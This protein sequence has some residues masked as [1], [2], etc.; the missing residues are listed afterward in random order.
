MQISSGQFRSPQTPQYLC[1]YPSHKH[2]LPTTCKTETALCAL[3]QLSQE[4]NPPE[5]MWKQ[6]HSSRSLDLTKS[7]DLGTML[8]TPGCRVDCTV[9]WPCWN[10][11][12]DKYDH[13]LVMMAMALVLFAISNLQAFKSNSNALVGQTGWLNSCSCVV[14]RTTKGPETI[15]LLAS[16][17]PHLT[18]TLT[19]LC[20]PPL[21]N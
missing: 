9:A 2:V 15:S 3:R 1:G 6:V 13:P 17:G 18:G 20:R 19:S 5:A 21:P 14:Y 16:P 12:F 4:T 7:F 10:K 8:G 11:G